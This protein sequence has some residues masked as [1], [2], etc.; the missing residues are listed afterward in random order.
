MRGI[1]CGLFAAIVLCVLQAIGRAADQP[2][3]TWRIEGR[4]V[5]ADQRPVAGAVVFIPRLRGGKFKGKLSTTTDADGRLQLESPLAPAGLTLLANLHDGEQLAYRQLPWDLKSDLP[6]DAVQ[7]VLR[8]ARKLAVEVRDENGKSVP[9]ATVIATA[10]YQEMDSATTAADGRAQLDVPADAELKAV[11]A[12]KPGVGLDYTLFRSGEEPKTDP[13]RL[14]QDHAEPLTFVLNG[15]HKIAVRVV[16]ERDR[17]LTG[18]DVYPWLLNRPR[19]GDRLNLS[20]MPE[21]SATTDANGVAT[22]DVIPTDN[23]RTVTFWVQAPGYF[24]PEQANYKPE[25]GDTEL[26]VRLLPLVTVSGSVKFA[27]GRPAAGVEVW[28]AGAGYTRDRFRGQTTTDSK[29]HFTLQVNPDQYYQFAAGNR[30]WASPPVNRIVRTGTPVEG[31]ELQLQPAKRVFGRVTLGADDIPVPGIYVRLYQQNA[32]GYY[33]LPD[34]EQLPNPT[35]SHLAIQPQI[36]WSGPTNDSGE[37]EFFVGPGKYYM[38]GPNGV[39]PPHFELVDQPSMEINL[40][41]ERPDSVPISGR[42]VR[43]DQPTQGVAEVGVEGVA[44]QSRLGGLRATSGTDGRFQAQRGPADM[45]VYATTSDHKLA[46][47]VNIGPDDTEVVIPV[48]PTASAHARLV[49]SETNAPLANRQVEYGVWI[50]FEEGTF[51]WRF[52]GR[53]TTDKN[54]EIT[55]DGLVVGQEYVLEAVTET[56]AD[57]QPRS[58]IGAGKV[59]PTSTERAE[60]GDV[61][62]KRPYHEPTIEERVAK[63]FADAQSLDERLEA[64]LRDAG[65]GYQNVL[66]VMGDP[67]NPPVQQVYEFEYDEALDRAAMDYLFFPVDTS[68]SERRAHAEAALAPRMITVPAVGDPTLAVLDK[69]GNLVRQT[70][71]SELT[72]DGK[73]DAA[74]LRGFLKMNA[75]ALP[76]AELQLAGALAQAK[77]EDKRVFVQV[78]GPRC[79]WCFVLSRFLDD[80]RDV[81]D[82]EFVYVKLDARFAHGQAVI[83][84]VRPAATG[85]IPW[86]V[87]LDSDGTPL[88]N[89]DGPSGNIGYPGEPDGQ[90]YFEKMLRTSPRHITD[91]EIK[92]L[93]AD[94]AAKNH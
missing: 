86:F 16:D 62:V 88:I 60:M 53:A 50:D 41:A 22:F 45:V 37:F 80:H 67:A 85:G 11:V 30:E 84:Q 38:S 76:D 47:I 34:S 65:F 44:K 15:T 31:I 56:S 42:V 36:G 23:S 21:F 9:A 8:P 74:K 40:H 83:D 29:G 3:K 52:G 82:K 20:G 72:T 49:D 12:F 35:D 33:D 91:D 25:S 19:K 32:V 46:G 63:A 64:R 4:V 5:D 2:S 61:A 18:L 28:A 10:S 87:I 24:A 93:I 73:V 26:V 78:S 66:V 55:I 90:V 27:D 94:L 54:G 68:D 13:C 48:A 70:A 77:R 69:K 58:W 81:F 71:C 59:T 43:K 6:V 17:P 92:S 7:L 75:P 57:G 39:A 14:A 79:G 1:R 89:S 51:S